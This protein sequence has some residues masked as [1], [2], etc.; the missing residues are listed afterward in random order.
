[1]EVHVAILVVDIVICDIT[2]FLCV[3]MVMPISISI[4]HSTLSPPHLQPHHLNHEHTKR[5]QFPSY[6]T[7]RISDTHIPRNKALRAQV[8][9]IMVR[10]AVPQVGVES[11]EALEV[12]MNVCLA[13]C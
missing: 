8:H 13:F 7:T 5:T 11:Q 10:S 3:D 9:V 1:M 4:P 2:G 6:S 12:V